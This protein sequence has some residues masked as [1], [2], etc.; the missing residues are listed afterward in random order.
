MAGFFDALRIELEGSGVSVTV[1]HPG[2]V[3]SEIN[4]HALSGDGTPYGDRAYIRQPGETMPTEECARL[5]LRATVRRDRD[6]VM[7]WRGKIG[8]LL[9]LIS[10]RLVDRIAK[11]AIDTRQ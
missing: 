10:P 1:V 8:R 4:R 5:I 3:F 11:R 2:F 6:L 9:K 7:T